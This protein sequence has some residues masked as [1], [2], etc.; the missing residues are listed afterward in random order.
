MNSLNLSIETIEHAYGLIV[1]QMY[2]L[3]HENVCFN[4]VMWILKILVLFFLLF[5]IYL[6]IFFII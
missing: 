2:E 5:I 6:L 4:L 3:K 1:C